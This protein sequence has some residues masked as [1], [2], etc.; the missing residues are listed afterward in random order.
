MLVLICPLSSNSRY[1][2]KNDA[3]K[4]VSVVSLTSTQEDISMEEILSLTR[5][6]GL[7]SV[8]KR[9]QDFKLF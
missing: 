5:V 4:A 6:A 8:V 3:D 7:K 1:K 9:C 2:S